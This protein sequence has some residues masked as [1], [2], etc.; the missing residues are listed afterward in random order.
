MDKNKINFKVKSDSNVTKCAL[1]LYK[2]I[3]EGNEVELSA[4]GAGAV[5]QG[6]KVVTKAR[7][8]LAQGGRDLWLRVGMRNELIA[9][10]DM[11]VVVFSFRVE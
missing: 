10:K 2:L 3:E 5:N 6:V 4:I 9:E 7:A 11:S 8:H 1:S